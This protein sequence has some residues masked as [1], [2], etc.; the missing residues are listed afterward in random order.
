MALTR[1]LRKK[2]WRAVVKHWP[3]A[4]KIERFFF[5]S[6]VTLD[7]TDRFIGGVEMKGLVYGTQELRWPFLSKYIRHVGSNGSED[8][9]EASFL[10]CVAMKNTIKEVPRFSMASIYPYSA[11]EFSRYSDSISY[12]IDWSKLAEEPQFVEGTIDRFEDEE[13]AELILLEK[14]AR[15]YAEFFRKFF[16]ISK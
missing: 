4:E 8:I 5:N 3:E 1:S 13:F 15:K 9:Y 7:Y 2:A 12:R 16:C 11:V 6:Q 14:K 10:N